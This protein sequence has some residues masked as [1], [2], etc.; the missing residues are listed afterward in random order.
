[1]TA[2]PA[3]VANDLALQAQYFAKRD[4]EVSATCHDCARVIR[5]FLAGEKVD[6]RTYGGVHVRMLKMDKRYTGETQ[7]SKSVNR[8]LMT[9]QL[10]HH[11][12]AGMQGR[13]VRD[14]E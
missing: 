11:E 13:L 14:R 3:Q 12:T 10:L 5:A 2:T 1:M 9:L 8:G 7:I 6:G 4:A